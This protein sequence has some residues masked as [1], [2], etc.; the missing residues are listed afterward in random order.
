MKSHSTFD[1]YDRK[2]WSLSDSGHFVDGE[3]F[4]DLRPYCQKYLSTNRLKLNN[5]FPES[6]NLLLDFASG[7]IQYD[8]YMSYSVNYKKRICIDLSSSALAL[9][10][11]RSPNH[12]STLCGDII[13]LDLRAYSFDTIL[14][15]HTIYH[16]PI[17][18]QIYVI[19]KLVNSLS[20]H[21]TLV[22]VYSNPNFILERL[23]SCFKS[24]SSQKP[25]F[26]FERLK[27]SEIL[28]SFPSC[29]LVPYRALSGEDMKRTLP[30]N[31]IG[32]FFLYLLSFAEK[33]LPLILVQYYLIV[34]KK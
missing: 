5:Y 17:Q 8:E 32:S 23:K 18:S 1:F 6:G 21:G 30:N 9:A 19:Q 2:G 20:A 27:P 28:R 25:E 7:P 22:I 3:L 24:S 12:I 26:T 14:S 11:S 16:I 13:D 33:F 29:S 31:I 34:I 10:K 15:L 4:E